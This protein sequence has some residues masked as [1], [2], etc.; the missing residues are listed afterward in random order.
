MTLPPPPPPPPLHQLLLPLPLPLVIH[1]SSIFHEQIISPTPSLL[2]PLSHLGPTTRLTSTPIYPSYCTTMA[3][4]KKNKNVNA[5]AVQQALD[6]Q[7]TYIDKAEMKKLMKEQSRPNI[8]KQWNEYFGRGDLADWQGL[9][10]DLLFEETFSSKTQCRKVRKAPP[11]FFHPL[12]SFSLF[13]IIPV[14]A[15]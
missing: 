8:V 2:L 7:A 9:M 1:S 12:S 11:P 4:K 6:I 5:A 3:R 14:I 15:A 13:S 10:R